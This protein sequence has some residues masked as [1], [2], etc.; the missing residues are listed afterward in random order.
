MVE[1][2]KREKLLSAASSSKPMTLLDLRDLGDL[3]RVSTV[4]RSHVTIPKPLSGR[5]PASNTDTSLL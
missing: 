4:S 1:F 3:E 2:W 5:L